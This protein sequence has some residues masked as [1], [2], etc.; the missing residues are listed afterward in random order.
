M[1]KIEAPKY[2]Y[3]PYTDFN[4]KEYD[5]LIKAKNKNNIARVAKDLENYPM[6]EGICFAVTGSDGKLE[7]HLQS[8]TELIIFLQKISSPYES[9]KEFSKWYEEA[10]GAPIGTF[11]VV[12]KKIGLPETKIISNDTPLSYF[13]GEEA[14]IY[15]DRTLN[16]T[17]VSGNQKLL[18]SAKQ[19]VLE[20]ATADN[21][22]GQII[23]KKMKGQ[24][25]NYRINLEKGVFHNSQTFTVNVDPP[26]QYYNENPE[27]YT[28]GF[29]TSALR[30]TQRET[31][32]LTIHA[33][34]SGA[35]SIKEA[36]LF[37]TNT[38]ERINELKENQIIPKEL[39][40]DISYRWFLQKYHLAQEKYRTSLSPVAAP[41]S[42][43]EFMQHK[44][45]V[46][47]YLEILKDKPL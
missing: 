41:F 42:K 6:N 24:L 2:I 17:F 30:A 44:Q 7:R 23:R 22:V 45:V 15:P 32:L 4:P 38:V 19:Q 11:Y 36:S 35:L 37:P 43:G 20:E 28:V 5:R 13:W 39:P 14:T 47:K 9:A 46:L 10:H 26:L 1:I 31:D 40:I 18:N 21:K 16:A 25:K 3:S 12:D 29:K 33:I 27:S 8:K 34:R